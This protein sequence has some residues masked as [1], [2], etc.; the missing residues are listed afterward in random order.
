MKITDKHFL[1]NIENTINKI[2]NKE[3]EFTLQLFLSIF[4]YIVDKKHL[5]EEMVAYLAQYFISKN[6]LENEIF[7]FLD[8]HFNIEAI[9]FTWTKEVR[10]INVQRKEVCD[11]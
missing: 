10:V 8:K 3:V 2:K 5:T 11:A 9:E 1:Q 7:L 6:D 4:I